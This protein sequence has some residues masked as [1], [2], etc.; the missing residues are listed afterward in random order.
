MGILHQR[1]NPKVFEIVDT[2]LHLI[3]LE[4]QYSSK[5]KDSEQEKIEQEIKLQKRIDKELKMDANSLIFDD[6]FLFN[7]DV[8]TTVEISV[9]NLFNIK[10]PGIY[11]V[12]MVFIT[13]KSIDLSNQILSSKINI[14]SS[15][16]CI[17]YEQ[18]YFILYQTKE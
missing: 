1:E 3:G 10:E 15:L 16:N 8:I 6:T 2:I 5:L 4:D 14:N 18:G 17:E 11:I 12:S 7:M 9:D 13:D